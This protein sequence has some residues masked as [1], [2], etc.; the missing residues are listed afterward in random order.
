MLSVAYGSFHMPNPKSL[1]VGDRVRFTSLPDEWSRKGYTIP[2]ES[3]RFMKVMVKRR[4]ASRVAE[5]DEY[6]CPWI[7]ARI[8]VR[9][10]IHHH[11]WAIMESTGWR[12]VNRAK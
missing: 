8:R 6:G 1:K 2:L 4:W 12:L 9:G 10:R 11:R 7:H 3:V 5:I